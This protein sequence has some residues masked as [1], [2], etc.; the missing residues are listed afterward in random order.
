MAA[1]PEPELALVPELVLGLG[2]A[3]M[4][5]SS[6]AETVAEAEVWDDD[7]EPD[8]EAVPDAEPVAD[9]EAVP[10]GEPDGEAVPDGEPVPDGELDGTGEFGLTFPC[11]CTWL[12][13]VLG[14]GLVL[15]LVLVLGL[16]LGAGEVEEL[17]GDGVGVEDFVGV[18][19]G[20][21]V[22][23]LE[24]GSSWHVVAVLALAEVPELDEAAVSLI[25][26]PGRE[27]ASSLALPGSGNPRPAR[28]VPLLVRAET[29]ENRPAYAAHQGY[30]LLSVGSAALSGFGGDG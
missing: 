16:G 12:V 28:W 4:R 22:G 9:G 13:L 21:G 18:G 8:G 30:C 3:T 7:G 29:H 23:V 2:L 1:E 25:V 17:E 6:Q 14:L 19:V 26:L 11:A 20:V 5:A 15:G 27:S 10:D 24:A